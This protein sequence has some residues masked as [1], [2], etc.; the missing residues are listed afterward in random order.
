VVELSSWKETIFDS[1]TLQ[2]ATVMGHEKLIKNAIVVSQ[3]KDEIQIM[4]PDT[5][6]VVYVRKPQPMFFDSDKVKIV[7]LDDHIFLFPEKT[8]L[9]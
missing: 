5:Y 2:K 7:K 8:K 1:K 4:D 3:S 6:K 9:F